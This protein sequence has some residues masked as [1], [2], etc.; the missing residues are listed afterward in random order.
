[1]PPPPAPHP[2]GPLHGLGLTAFTWEVGTALL[3]GR[4]GEEVGT[5]RIPPGSGVPQSTLSTGEDSVRMTKPQ[6]AS[7]A[8][9]YRDP[10]PLK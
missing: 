1:M 10:N 8:G 4:E 6:V 2:A 5:H 3:V 9:P 7:P